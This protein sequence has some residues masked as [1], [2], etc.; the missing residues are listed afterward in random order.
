MP[1][2]QRPADLARHHRQ[3]HHPV[4]TT[5]E[6][7][8]ELYPSSV[9]ALARYHW[10]PV[11]IARRAADFL[12]QDKKVKV[13]DIGSGIGKFCLVAAHF[14]PQVMF[15]G[16]E[17][18][19]S[20]VT[21]ADNVK[22]A[23]QL[24]NVIFRHGNF[25]QLNFADYDHFYFFNAFYENISGVRK[26]DHTIDHSSELYHYYTRYL[27]K[28]LQQRPYGTRLVTFHSLEDEIPEEY[29]LVLSQYDNM[30]KF[31]VKQ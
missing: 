27:Y 28:E 22:S 3:T 2:Q 8:D 21:D 4:F 30:L 23:L 17:Q 12:A 10:T 16:I 13:L 6:A 26:I 20:L 7:F 11:E 25:T 18:R 9:R 15:Y 1:M 31:W 14:N 5:D 24:H 19:K 29:C